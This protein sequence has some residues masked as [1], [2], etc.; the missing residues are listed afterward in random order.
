MVAK[1]NPLYANLAVALVI[2]V[3]AFRLGGLVGP[4]EYRISS[5]SQIECSR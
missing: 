4:S 3:L 1:L 5:A 2:S